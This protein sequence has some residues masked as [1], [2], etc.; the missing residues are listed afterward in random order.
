MV[1]NDSS[2]T[3][4]SFNWKL[5]FSQV[6]YVDK[7]AMKQLS[8]SNQKPCTNGNCTACSPVLVSYKKKDQICRRHKPNVNMANENILIWIKRNGKLS[9]EYVYHILPLFYYQKGFWNPK[10]IFHNLIFK[11][12][13]SIHASTSWA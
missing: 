1:T 5:N 13:Q 4:N 11:S 2:V 9:H 10:R 3:W 8:K 12:Q 7:K 6:P